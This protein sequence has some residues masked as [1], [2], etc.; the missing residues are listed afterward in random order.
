MCEAC[1]FGVATVVNSK[2]RVLGVPFQR[3]IRV[4]IRDL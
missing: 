2:N 1:E 3:G 4:T